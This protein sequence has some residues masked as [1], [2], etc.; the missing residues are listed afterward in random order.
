VGAG[1]NFK[2]EILEGIVREK[3]FSLSTFRVYSLPGLNAPR[4]AALPI[5]VFEF[6]THVA[7]SAKF[8]FWIINFSAL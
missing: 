4:L 2:R 8:H 5:P 7:G 1:V 6:D 3:K